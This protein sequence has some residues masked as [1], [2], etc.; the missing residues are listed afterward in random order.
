MCL[1]AVLQVAIEDGQIY[2]YTDPFGP[3]YAS[4]NTWYAEIYEKAVEALS[5]SFS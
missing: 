4:D 2:H 1:G 5:K 3:M